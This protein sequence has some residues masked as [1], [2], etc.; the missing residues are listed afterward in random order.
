M[1]TDSRI[2]VR[3]LSANDQKELG[4]LLE[5]F[6]SREFMMARGNVVDGSASYEIRAVFIHCVVFVSL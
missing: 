3:V 5:T 6:K 4:C 1:S 2:S